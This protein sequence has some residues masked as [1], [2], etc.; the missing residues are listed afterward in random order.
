MLLRKVLFSWIITTRVKKGRREVKMTNANETTMFE[1]PV[2]IHVCTLIYP[3]CESL[4]FVFF[5]LIPVMYLSVRSWGPLN[6]SL[7]VCCY[8]Y[9]STFSYSFGSCL[10][11]VM[12]DSDVTINIF[13]FCALLTSTLSCHVRT[14]IHRLSRAEWNIKTPRLWKRCMKLVSNQSRTYK[15]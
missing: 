4:F 7:N 2:W 9:C 14:L 3:M 12:N 10:N 5:P 6:H 8:Y 13:Y 11:Y 1:R 15:L